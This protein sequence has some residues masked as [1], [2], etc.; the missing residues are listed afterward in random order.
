MFSWNKQTE[1]F[2]PVC[3]AHPIEYVFS[4]F[5]NNDPPAQS[6]TFF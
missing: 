5:K 3:S 4:K 1:I 6:P 2:N